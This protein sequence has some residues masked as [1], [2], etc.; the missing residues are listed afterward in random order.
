MDDAINKHLN[1]PFASATAG[2]HCIVIPGQGPYLYGKSRGT[3]ANRTIANHKFGVEL[4]NQWTWFILYL[5]IQKQLAWTYYKLI[6]KWHIT[7]RLLYS[8]QLCPHFLLLWFQENTLKILKNFSMRRQLP[9]HN[10]VPKEFRMRGCTKITKSQ[11]LHLQLQKKVGWRYQFRHIP[12][13][14]FLRESYT[15]LL[16]ISHFPRQ[17]LNSYISAALHG[18]FDC[19]STFRYS[20]SEGPKLQS[21]SSV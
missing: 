6:R 21:L 9:F 1:L 10:G 19:K 11:R 2:R 3:L 14:S 13:W 17:F 4:E 5:P 7:V 20:K 12:T 16:S 18:N 8:T 15:Y